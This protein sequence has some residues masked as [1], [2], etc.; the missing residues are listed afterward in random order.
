MEKMATA[1]LVKEYIRRDSDRRAKTH[2]C[3]Y[4]VE[5]FNSNESWGGDS[6]LMGEGEGEGEGR[7][8]GGNETATALSLNEQWRS[9]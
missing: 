1:L 4:G 7:R 8:E 9:P 3:S 5:K 6:S 2:D